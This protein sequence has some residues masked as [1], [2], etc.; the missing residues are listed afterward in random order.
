ML[1]DKYGC[2][3]CDREE[4]CKKEYGEE[5]QAVIG[6]HHCRRSWNNFLVK[7]IEERSK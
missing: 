4:E 7:N 1:K 3:N 6:T 5:Y 2:E